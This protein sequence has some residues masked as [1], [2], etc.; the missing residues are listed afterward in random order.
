[1]NR[2]TPILSLLFLPAVQVQYEHFFR[3]GLQFQPVVRD[4]H[5]NGLGRAVK[6]ALHRQYIQSGSTVFQFGQR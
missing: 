5:P 6:R 3:S 4:R 2:N 1:M